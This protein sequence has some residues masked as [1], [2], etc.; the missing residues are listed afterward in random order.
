MCLNESWNDVGRIENDEIRLERCC[1]VGERSLK[2]TPKS[3]NSSQARFASV[4]KLANAQQG[5]YKKG[6]HHEQRHEE[7]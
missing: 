4:L 7:S 6:T 3:Q 1:S 2:N 5:F